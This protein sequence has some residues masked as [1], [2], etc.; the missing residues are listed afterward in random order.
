MKSA[1]ELALRKQRLQIQAKQQRAELLAAL[2]TVETVE[3][4]L[5]RLREG[6]D[7]LREH[8]PVVSVLVLVLLV[9]RPSFTLRWIKRAWLGWRLYLRFRGG[10]ASAMAAL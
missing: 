9:A 3:H 8:A 10:L 1:Q 5:T 2:E 4:K 6:V 7:W